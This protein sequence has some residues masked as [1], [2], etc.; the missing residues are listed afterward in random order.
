LE[1]GADGVADLPFQ[2]AQG[3]FG[4]LAFG[5]FRVVAGAARAVPVPDLGDRGHVDG[6]AGPAVAAPGQAPDFAAAGGH[7]DGGGAGAGGEVVPVRE[8]GHGADVAD[9]RGTRQPASTAPAAPLRKLRDRSAPLDPGSRAHESGAYKGHGH[10]L[11]AQNRPSKPAQ[12]PQTTGTPAHHL[13]KLDEPVHMSAQIR[14]PQLANQQVSAV[15]PPRI[16]DREQSQVPDG[17]DRS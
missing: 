16:H 17:M 15:S 10:T 13:Q 11:P 8:A 5:Q 6:V 9:D 3:L 12:T 14:L 7:L 4:S 2:A 1:A